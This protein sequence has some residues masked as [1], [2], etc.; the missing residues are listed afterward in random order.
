MIQDTQ[1]AEISQKQDKHNIH[2]I[3]KKMCPHGYHHNSFVATHA[4]GRMMYGYMLLVPMNQGA[5]NKLRKICEI[6]AIYVSWSWII[7]AHL[8]YVPSL[9]LEHSL[10]HWYQQ[11]VTVYPVPKCMRCHKAIVMITGKAHC[12]HYYMYIMPILLLWNFS[13]LCILDHC[14]SITYTS[15]KKENIPLV[16]SVMETHY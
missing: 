16:H 15:E 5:L 12:F 4:F 13:T 11:C 7:Y 10:V 9:A 8:Y 6:W 3:M 14:M 2:V 1:S